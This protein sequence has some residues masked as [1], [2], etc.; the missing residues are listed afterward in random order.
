[1]AVLCEKGS[2]VLAAQTRNLKECG[3]DLVRVS[4]V[5]D[6]TNAGPVDA[7]LVVPP[8]KVAVVDE[9]WEKAGW[10]DS[11][12]WVHSFSAGVD[13]MA[14]LTKNRLIPGNIPLSNGRGAFSSSLAEYAITTTLYFNKQVARWQRNRAEKKWDRFT[15]DT[16][17]GKQMGF[18]GFGDI[19]QHTAQLAKACGMRVGVLRRNP[20]K[21]DSAL[22]DQTYTEKED[23]LRDSDFILASLP[24]TPETIDFVSR[25]EFNAMK[26]GAVFISCGRGVTVDE[27]ALYDA[28]KAEKIFAALDVFKVEPLPETSP[29]WS[30]PD[31]RFLVTAHNADLTSDYLELGWGV[32]YDNLDAFLEGKDLSTPVNKEHGY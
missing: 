12:Q 2:A 31:D 32:F 5:E 25:A 22:V 7:L 9:A 26:D 21:N 29:L 19:A 11:V 1:V 17:K 15:M 28:V 18:L 16:I 3:V 6:V 4:S 13:A 30:L 10:N 20:Q 24:G 23:I 27:E 14:T 8:A